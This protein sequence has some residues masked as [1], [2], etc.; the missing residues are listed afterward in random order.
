M[1]N[2]SYS[3]FIGAHWG[4]LSLSA[5]RD[6]YAFLRD[7]F[8]HRDCQTILYSHELERYVTLKGVKGE[9]QTYITACASLCDLYPFVHRSVVT[10]RGNGGG[11]G[12][13]VEE[14]HERRGV[15]ET[16]M[17]G[18]TSLNSIVVDEPSYAITNPFVLEL[19]NL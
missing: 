4:G 16:L 3:P 18:N 13:D 9:Q 2:L 14:E 6:S 11:R 12:R 7:T 8:T 5:P 10:R 1:T 17:I 19:I 15:V